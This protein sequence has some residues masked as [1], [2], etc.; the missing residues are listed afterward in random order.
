MPSYKFNFVVKKLNPDK[1]SC[2]NMFISPTCFTELYKTTNTTLKH[3]QYNQEMLSGSITSMRFYFIVPYVAK[4]KNIYGPSSQTYINYCYTYVKCKKYL[5]WYSC[6]LT[7][8]I[9]FVLLFLNDIL[10]ELCV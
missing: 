9:P 5:L 1:S 7:V 3:Q 8:T 4:E 10:L 6:E 2:L